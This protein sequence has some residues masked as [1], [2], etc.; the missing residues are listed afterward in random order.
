MKRNVLL[1]LG[2]ATVVGGLCL[3][4][5]SSQIEGCPVVDLQEN[6]DVSRYVGSWFEHARDATIRFERGNC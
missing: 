1:T 2:A 3:M 4:L 5:I 6:F